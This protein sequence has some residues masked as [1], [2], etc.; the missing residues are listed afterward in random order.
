MSLEKKVLQS[1]GLKVLSQDH[2]V[3]SSERLDRL[4]KSNFG[5]SLSVV[6]QL[7]NILVHKALVPDKGRPVHLYWALSYL[8]LYET[9]TVFSVMFSVS[10]K[11][12][13]KWVLKFV[14]AISEIDNVRNTRTCTSTCTNLYGFFVCTV[15]TVITKIF[16]SNLNADS[17]GKSFY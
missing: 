7:W 9:E 17:L 11:T 2:L 15:C 3:V 16:H 12:F 1:I 10:E 14:V 13:K 6:F 5:I 8:K 4:Y